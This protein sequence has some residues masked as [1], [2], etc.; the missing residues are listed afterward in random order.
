MRYL[1]LKHDYEVQST[2]K[3]VKEIIPN[4]SRI[5]MPSEY[6]TTIRGLKILTIYDRFEP[7]L[8]IEGEED[9]MDMF[10]SKLNEEQSNYKTGK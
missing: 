4:L 6:E 3:T 8:K 10:R 2:I 9:L 7:V 1:D 5:I